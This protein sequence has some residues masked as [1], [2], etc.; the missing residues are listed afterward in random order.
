[1]VKETTK[2]NEESGKTENNQ[3]GEKVNPTEEKDEKLEF[4]AVTKEVVENGE[5]KKKP[6]TVTSGTNGIFE[7]KKLEDGIYAVEETK[8][9]KDYVRL[10]RYVFFFKVEGGKIYKINEYG[11]Y[12]DMKD[13]IVKDEEK[14]KALIVNTESEIKFNAEL[15]I[16]NLKA[17]YPHTGGVGALPFIFIGMMIMMVGAYMF[18][19]RRDALYE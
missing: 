12:V 14:D 17:E 2:T 16:E 15:L 7:F 8:A 3:D 19:R 1:M 6:Y 10:K 18:I 9:P 11:K 4:E 13:K 5:P